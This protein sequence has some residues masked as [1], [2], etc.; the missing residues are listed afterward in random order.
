MPDLYFDEHPHL[1][2]IEWDC[3]PRG[4]VIRISAKDYEDVAAA[5]IAAGETGCVNKVYPKCRWVLDQLT[6]DEAGFYIDFECPYREVLLCFINRKMLTG[7][8]GP[9]EL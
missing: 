5:L 2:T 6:D 9:L 1:G 7:R 4:L 3:R 8:S